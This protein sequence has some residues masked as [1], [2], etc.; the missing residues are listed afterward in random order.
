MN[1]TSAFCFLANDIDKHSNANRIYL[2]QLRKVQPQFGY[3]LI[4]VS[5]KKVLQTIALIGVDKPMNRN[6]QRFGFSSE[7]DFHS[8][9]AF[10]DNLRVASQ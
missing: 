7:I 6:H 1:G 4:Q 8:S 2:V 5:I 10:Y 9:Y 3:S